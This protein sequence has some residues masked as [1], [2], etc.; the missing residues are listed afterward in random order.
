MR[1]TKLLQDK[2]RDRPRRKEKGRGTGD[3]GGD[4]KEKAGEERSGTGKVGRGGNPCP[5]P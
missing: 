5:Q 3:N 1:A 4:K 2:K